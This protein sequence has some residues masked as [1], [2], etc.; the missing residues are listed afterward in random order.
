MRAVL[1]FGLFMMAALCLADKPFPDNPKNHWVY[2]TMR[3][4][5]KDK[6]WYRQADGVPKRKVLTRLDLATKTMYLAFDS[7]SLVG[8]F[9]SLISISTKKPYDVQS[10]KWA[11]NFRKSFPKKK[12]LYQTHMKRVIKLWNFFRPEMAA[13]GKAL[14]VDP[15]AAGQRLLAEQKELN[16]LSLSHT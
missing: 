4:I 12:A 5:A 2:A 1:V 10:K 11:A 3:A 15:K 8:S 6:L 9:R 13:V 7:N 16:G 14:H